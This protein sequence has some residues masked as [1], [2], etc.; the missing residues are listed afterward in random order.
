MVEAAPSSIQG[1][2][3]GALPTQTILHQHHQHHHQQ[4]QQPTATFRASGLR[5]LAKN[6]VQ[7]VQTTQHA[8]R[9]EPIYVPQ[10]PVAV[11][12]PALPS[13]NTFRK[14][15]IIKPETAITS[16]T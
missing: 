13:V 14:S 3:V 5:G 1:A 7:G 11:S 4:P 6:Y 15:A 16:A 2:I 9:V 10:I 8:V 12:Q